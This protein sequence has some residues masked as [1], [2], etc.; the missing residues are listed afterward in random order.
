MS[1]CGNNNDLALQHGGFCTTWSLAAKRLLWSTNRQW[2]VLTR[3]LNLQAAFTF[4]AKTWTLKM[5]RSLVSNPITTSDFFSKP[6]TLLWTQTLGTITCY[7]QK[8]TKALCENELHGH[9][10]KLLVTILSIAYDNEFRFHFTDEGL[11]ISRN[12]CYQLSRVSGKP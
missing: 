11:S 1:Q 12:V 8:P 6:G 2:Q 7:Y 9:V 3:T 4:S 5:S 10:R